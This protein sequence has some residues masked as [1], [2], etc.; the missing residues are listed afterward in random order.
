MFVCFE[1]YS[2]RNGMKRFLKCTSCAVARTSSSRS[3]TSSAEADILRSYQ[4]HANR[5][6]TKPVVDFL[7]STC[8]L[9]RSLMHSNAE[10]PLAQVGHT[11]VENG[12][13]LFRENRFDSPLATQA[14]LFVPM[15]TPDSPCTRVPNR[16]LQVSVQRLAWQVYKLSATNRHCLQGEYSSTPVPRSCEASPSAPLHR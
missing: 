7:H 12:S 9:L 8:R 1:R 13:G 11:G 2:A 14:G 15:Q 3:T 5:Y 4:L 10:V 16:I 6:I